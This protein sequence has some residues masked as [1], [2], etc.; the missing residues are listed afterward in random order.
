MDRTQFGNRK[1]YP[2]LQTQFN[3]VNGVYSPDGR[4][5]AYASDE[6][7]R[8]EIYVQSF[9]LSGAK[10][11]VS[12]GGGTESVW[13]ND[14]T[15]LFYEASDQNLMAAPVKSGA[16]FEGGAPMS[17]FRVPLA[18]AAGVLEHHTYAVSNDGQRF[19]MAAAVG[20][21]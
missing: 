3:E 19:L 8:D 15:E 12:T 9:P 1:P 17:L 20:G 11:Q 13:R 18:S 7:G 4:W 6:S 16:K 2:Y 10:F 14:G 21:E 5:V